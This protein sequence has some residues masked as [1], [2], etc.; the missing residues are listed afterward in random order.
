[1]FDSDSLRAQFAMEHGDGATL[2]NEGAEE[3]YRHYVEWQLRQGEEDAD[4]GGMA[5]VT[6]TT[7]IVQV[8]R[9]TGLPKMD[10]NGKA[11]P[12]VVLS[13]GEGAEQKSKVMPKT[14]SPVWDD[15]QFKFSVLDQSG[16]LVRRACIPWRKQIFSHLPATDVGADNV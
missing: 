10:R 15:A 4:D 1:M 9:A 2:A 5:I 14:L 13:C 8:L 3:I 11:D 12:Y 16:E 6:E 7:V